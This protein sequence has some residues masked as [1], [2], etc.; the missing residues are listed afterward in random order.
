[1]RKNKAYITATNK[2]TGEVHEKLI[3]DVVNVLYLN[4]QLA[5]IT[6]IDEKMRLQNY[7]PCFEEYDFD[8]SIC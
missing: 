3:K 1:M 8:I 2:K 6:Y 7:I 5:Q 4:N